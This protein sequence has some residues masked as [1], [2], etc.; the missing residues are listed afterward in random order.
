MINFLIKKSNWKIEFLMKFF[1]NLKIKLEKIKE[2]KKKIKDSNKKNKTLKIVLIL[3]II[4]YS[5]TLP[6]PRRC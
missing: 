5:N 1:K 2:P 3:V 6:M 4:M